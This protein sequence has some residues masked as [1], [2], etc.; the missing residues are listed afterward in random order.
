VVDSI[1]VTPLLNGCIVQLPAE[2]NGEGCFLFKLFVYSQFVLVRFHL[3]QLYL[4][5]M[6]KQELNSLHHCVYQLHYH[7]VL[8]TKYRRKVISPPIMQRLHEILS[9]T[10]EKWECKLLEFN[11]EPD[12]V[13][14][15]FESH[16]KIELSV[17][18]NNLKTVSS[19]L[20][21][22]DF[23]NEMRKVYWK[24]VFWHR[25]YCL[26]TCGGAPL[27]VIRQYIENQGKG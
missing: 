17:L 9:E 18:V 8:V 6:G 4:V 10:L 21:R 22:R 24:P 23:P 12:H 14:L 1:G 16:P 13:H 11:G 20:I 25:S 5:H 26:L 7:L 27:V 15:L 19:R 2:I 3:L